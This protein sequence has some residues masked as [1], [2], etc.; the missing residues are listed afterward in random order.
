M[1][2]ASAT[3]LYRC[4]ILG[5]YGVASFGAAL[6]AVALAG[7]AP[8]EHPLRHVA[9]LAARSGRPHSWPEWA[10]PDVIAAFT[11]R[12]IFAPWSHQARSSEFAH[13]GRHV[14]VSTGTA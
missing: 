5:G 11:G 10:E 13:A 6:P 2:I 8:G 9:E 12:V 7:T 3:D 1:F 14:V 4:R